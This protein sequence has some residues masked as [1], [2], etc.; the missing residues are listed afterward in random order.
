[1][2]SRQ[3]NTVEYTHT[4]MHYLVYKESNKIAAKFHC[5]CVKHVMLPI[6]ISSKWVI[7]MRECM[8][9]YSLTVQRAEMFAG[10]FSQ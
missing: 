4:Q 2:A 1:M 10:P 8:G 9:P 5:S 3:N 6:F 7:V